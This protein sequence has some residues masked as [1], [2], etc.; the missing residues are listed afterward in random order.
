MKEKG[1][2]FSLQARDGRKGVH[3]PDHAVSRHQL[4]KL[5]DAHAFGPSRAQ[6]QDQVAHISGAVVDPNF[7]V[8]GNPLP[9]LTHNATRI[10]NRP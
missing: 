5:L 1:A 6:W 9:E 8:V 10:D 2:V 7:H 3:D 4:L